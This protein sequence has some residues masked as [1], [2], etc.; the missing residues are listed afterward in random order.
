MMSFFWLVNH[1]DVSRQPL[2]QYAVRKPH[3]SYDCSDIGCYHHNNIR[4]CT[5]LLH[6]S[7]FR[8]AEF[9]GALFNMGDPQGDSIH[10][11]VAVVPHK[12]VAEVSEQE[13][14]RKPIGELVCCESRMIERIHW[15]TERWLEL[16]FFGVVTMVAVVTWPVTSPTAA[17]CNVVWCSC[18][19]SCG[20]V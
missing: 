12:A 4:Y 8:G 6:P 2:L 11:I 17:W 1:D 19:C 15:W 13:T 18:S 5:T 10:R 7:V 3:N 20:V 16:C 14:Y 9:V